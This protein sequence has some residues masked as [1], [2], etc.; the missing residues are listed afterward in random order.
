MYQRQDVFIGQLV[1]DMPKGLVYCV[2]D[3]ATRYHVARARV[4]KLADASHAGIIWHLQRKAATATGMTLAGN[5]SIYTII[6]I[7]I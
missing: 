4:V 2:G 7:H 6:Y 3:T 5:L 1:E